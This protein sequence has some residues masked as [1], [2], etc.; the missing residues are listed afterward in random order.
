MSDHSRQGRVTP[1]IKGFVV[2]I[3]EANGKTV[4]ASRRYFSRDAA[5]TYCALARKQGYDAWVE[6][7][8]GIDDV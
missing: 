3:K 5:D 6:S 7:E 2:K 4:K 1:V 8:M